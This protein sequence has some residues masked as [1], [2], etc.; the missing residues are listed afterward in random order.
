MKQYRGYYIDKVVFN[1][2]EE[3]DEHIK[4]QAVKSYRAAIRYFLEHTSMEASIQAGLKAEYLNT[5][6]GMSWSE[7]E[8]IEIMEMG[9]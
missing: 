2:K 9:A 6:C 8:E 5:Q 4:T 1:T 3:I 7:I